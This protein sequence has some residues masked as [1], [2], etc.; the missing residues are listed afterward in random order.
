MIGHSERESMENSPDEVPQGPKMPAGPA[1]PSAR[2]ENTHPLESL[3]ARNT[4]WRKM[5]GSKMT[6]D[7]AAAYG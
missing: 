3:F 5:T 4:S 7:E 2:N 1:M 6:G